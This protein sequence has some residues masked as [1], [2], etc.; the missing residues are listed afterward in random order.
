MWRTLDA[1][2]A[3]VVV[4]GHD[5]DY[6]RFARMHSDG[7]AAA[8]GVREFVVGTGGTWLRDF[9]SAVRNSQVRWNGS[10]G[11]LELTLRPA[12]YR[13]RFVPVAG[14]TFQDTGSSPCL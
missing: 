7:T 14:A 1:A 5:H 13:W 6:E 8:D 10:H 2:G 3:E 9:G 11:V 12:S 4:A